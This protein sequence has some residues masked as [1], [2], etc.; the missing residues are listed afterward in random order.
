LQHV[1]T[2]SAWYNIS[3]QEATYL[4]NNVPMIQVWTQKCAVKR[5]VWM[6]IFHI[7][8]FKKNNSWKQGSWIFTTSDYMLQ[9]FIKEILSMY[10]FNYFISL[11][12]FITAQTFMGTRKYK[13]LSIN[14]KKTIRGE[15]G[16]YMSRMI[17]S[18]TTMPQYILPCKYF[19]NH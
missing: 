9:Q 17:A 14:W 10:W 8:N 3:N 13:Y 16:N 18:K 6:S 4:N 19:L 15:K 2:C 5:Q 12:E 7:I 11:H 1:V